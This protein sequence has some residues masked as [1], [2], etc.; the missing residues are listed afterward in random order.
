MDVS[1]LHDMAIV[2]IVDGARLGRIKDVLF[3]TSAGR[4]VALRAE[5]GGQTFLVPLDQVKNIGA[6][7]VTVE[8]STVTQ[9]VAKNGPYSALPGIK[10]LKALKVVNTAGDFLGTPA[11]IEIDPSSG[12][13][14]GLTVHKGGILGLGGTTL[15]IAP[16][17]IRGIG[18]EL[19][20]VQAEPSAPPSQ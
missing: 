14:Q 15:S 18:A 17:D 8:N 7:A 6:D 12:R 10:R 20:T 16:E 3:D 9:A 11:T 5:H 1:K 13:L 2:S 4:A 19:I